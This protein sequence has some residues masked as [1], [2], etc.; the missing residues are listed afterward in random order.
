MKPNPT[1]SLL[2][3]LSSLRYRLFLPGPV[4]A[5]LAALAIACGAPGEAKAPEA[6]GGIDAGVDGDDAG[7]GDNDGAP[8]P[9]TD[10]G[11]ATKEPAP[12][13][14]GGSSASGGDAGT[15]RAQAEDSADA[16]EATDLKVAKAVQERSG[17][18]Q[19]LMASL[20]KSP[21]FKPKKYE[22][23]VSVKADGSVKKVDVDKKRS[24]VSAPDFLPCVVKQL[25]SATFPAPGRDITAR[26]IYPQ[27]G[28]N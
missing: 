24:D 9:R 26:V 23:V 10:A 20:E 12:R 6:S 4:G 3:P 17:H 22:I 19:C 15:A 8:G 28:A 18:R 14:D 25:Q 1:T 27:G 7:A 11:Q 16:K 21:G 2:S 13:G 5:T